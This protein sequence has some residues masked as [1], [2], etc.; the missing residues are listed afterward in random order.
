MKV[1]AIDIARALGISKATVSLALNGKPGVKD[2]TR[3]AILECKQALENGEEI[4]VLK[5]KKRSVFSE[6]MVKILIITR[7]LRMLHNSEIDLWTDVLSVFEKYLK[8]KGYNIGVSYLDFR[9]DTAESVAAVC[10]TDYV[11]GVIVSGTELQPEDYKKLALI[12]K[13]VV[14]YDGF[15]S[16]DDY[17]YVMIDNRQGV[18]LAVEELFSK[19]NRDIIYLGNPT[20]MYNFL[21]RRRGFIESME[22]RGITDAQKRIIDISDTIQGC[23]EFMCKYL[24]QGGRLPQA[25]LM[26]SYH[27]SIGVIRA[28]QE[29]NVKIPEDV[30]LIGIDTLPVYMTGG[31][32]YSCIRVPHTVRGYWTVQ[33]ILR[34]IDNMFNDKCKMYVNCELVPGE[35]VAIRK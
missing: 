20:S 21:S 6:K 14:I 11:D 23:Y 4:A 30:S 13:P 32:K 18:E 31:L 28:L 29:N 16:D 5:E 10:N 9:K 12:K 8:N 2:E 17:S 1:K 7:G 25:F 3:R 35:T 26:D 24:R 27:A 19:G 33:L 22:N 15:S 34:E